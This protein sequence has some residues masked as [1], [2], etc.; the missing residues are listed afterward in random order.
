MD[1]AD[2]YRDS[3]LTYEAVGATLSGG[4]PDGYVHDDESVPLGDGVA[5]FDAGRRAL[6]AWTAHRGSGIVVS[7]GAQV[8]KGE[9]VA[10]AARL[11]VGTALAV[12]RIVEVIDEAG[13]YGFAYGTLPL[14]PEEGEEA[15][16]IERDSE[17]RVRFRIIAFSK[18]RYWVARI[19]G[20]V[21]RRLQLNALDGYL[22]A[23]QQGVD[24][25]AP[26][27]GA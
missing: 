26:T 7:E 11:P 19:A 25:E 27:A 4:L 17:D 9:T 13:R 2:R 8:R 16:V 14:H 18:P 23:M 12:C 5:V 1:V 22:R 6:R 20:P 10:L 21:A 24:R 3:S 15:F